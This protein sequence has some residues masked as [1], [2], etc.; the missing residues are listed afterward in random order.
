MAEDVFGIVLKYLC[1]TQNVPISN[2]FLR[3][4]GYT[5]SRQAIAIYLH[6]D[7]NSVKHRV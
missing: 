7:V 5:K 4:L 2:G 1:T 6:C 3:N